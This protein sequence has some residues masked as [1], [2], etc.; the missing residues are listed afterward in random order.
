MSMDCSMRTDFLSNRSTPREGYAPVGNIQLYYREIGEGQP[1][2]VIHGG[3][4]FSHSYLLPDMDRLSDSFYLIYYDQRGRGRSTQNVQVEDVTIRSEIEDLE[5][6]RRYLGLDSIV[7]L[8][9]SWGGLLAMEYAVRYPDFVSHLILM[10]AAPASHEDYILFRQELARK[11]GFGDVE[12]LKA[13]LS[14]TQYQEGDLETDAKYYKLHFKVTLR[15]PEHLTRVIQN[16]RLNMN[17]EGILK[18]RA[19]EKR[20]Y[21]ETWFL[22]EYNLLPLLKRI[23][24]PTLVLHRGYDFIPIDIAARIAQAIPEARLVVLE[25][26][27]HFSYLECPD[28]VQKEIVDF[29]AN[30]KFSF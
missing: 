4:D 13:L 5:S 9:H 7:V 19:I 24:S 20:L 3:P 17:K 28:Q 11:R 1:I 29:L 27:G 21:D 6:L 10:N 25:E 2:I 14:S 26:C 12:T 22:G 18:A 23:G 16:L 15:E 8:G 30:N